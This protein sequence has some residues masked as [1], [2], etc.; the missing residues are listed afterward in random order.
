MRCGEESRG[1]RFMAEG[2]EP[3]PPKPLRPKQCHKYMQ[4]RVAEQFPA[5]V[6][7]FISEALKGSCPHMKLAVELLEPA[8]VEPRRR[9]SSI[10]MLLDQ[11]GE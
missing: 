3:A 2:E 10:H 8:K 11:L 9:K 1:E 5:I 7:G 6:N 4:K